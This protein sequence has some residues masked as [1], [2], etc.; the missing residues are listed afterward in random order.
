MNESLFIQWVAKYFGPLA[1]KVVEKI[2]GRVDGE[3]TYLF[4]RMLGTEYSPTMKWGSLGSNGVVVSADVV[5]MDS[6]LPLKKRD[7]LNKAEG[8]IPKIGMKMYLNERTMTDLDILQRTSNQEGAIIKKLFADTKKCISG[9]SE[10]LEFMFLELLSTGLTSTTD[11]NN[12]GALIR[13]D[14]NHPDSNKFGVVKPWSDPTSKPIDDINRVVKFAKSKGHV[15][16]NI[17]MDSDSFDSLAANEQTRQQYAFSQNFVGSQI[18][19]PD[20]DQ[21]NAVLGKKFKLAIEIV[22]RTIIVEKNGKRTAI[23]P[24]AANAVVFMTSN[25]GLGNVYHG[26]LAEE[27]HKVEGVTYEKVDEYILVSKYHKNDPIREYTSS[28]ALA[29]PVI[30]NIESIYILDCQE[31]TLD[32]QTEGNSTF[33]YKTVNYTK[34]S[35][36][37]ALKK[38]KPTTKL[39]VASTDAKLLDSINELSEEQILVFEANLVVAP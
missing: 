35:V 38:A 19:V 33:A 12:N 7:S 26:T 5:T 13:I 27:N 25:T 30:D 16:R 18:P 20:L 34:A 9:I 10:R 8:D 23:N 14:M 39:T 17:L 1:R 31:A 3:P 6:E 4:K 29:V 15:L 21:V 11:E 36:A 28:Q 32:V 24:W 37:D 2:N 22:D